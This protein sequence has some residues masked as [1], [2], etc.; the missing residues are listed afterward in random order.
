MPSPFKPPLVATP[1]RLGA[2]VALSVGLAACGGDPLELGASSSSAAVS[3]SAPASSS[4]A[5]SS[6]VASSARSSSLPASSSLLSRSSKASSSAKSSAS[7]AA[8]LVDLLKGDGA[9]A[10]GASNF[11]PYIVDAA[12]TVTFT[13]SADFAITKTSAQTYMVQITH[14]L[15]VA[16][17]TEY[18]VCFD[19]QAPSARTLDVA[20]DGGMDSD[21]SN[22]G[23]A[24][25]VNI[26]AGNWASYSQVITGVTT[27]TTARLAFNAGST[28]T[29]VNL[30]LDNIAVYVGNTCPASPQRFTVRP[31]TVQGS[32]I[33]Y[34]G[35]HT[36]Y[37]GVSLF[38]SDWGSKFYNANAVKAV[39]NEW[40]AKIIRAPLHVDNTGDDSFPWQ[41]YLTKD[42]ALLDASNK[43]RVFTVVDAAIA[44]DMYVIVDWHSHYAE[45]YKQQ[46]ID[47]FKEVA[48]KYGDKANLIYEIY[49]EPY[50]GT[51]WSSVIKPYAIDVIKAI[52]AID[53]DNL[54]IVGTQTYSQDVD[55]AANDPIQGFG[56]I[57][58]TLH[59][60]ADTHKA[61]MRSKATTALK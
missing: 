36:S 56:N 46:A 49:N 60:Y 47:F 21:Y 14:P 1:V 24:K 48:T 44:N 16:S 28:T 22:V 38:H 3:S 6:S 43:T 8:P 53:P 29:P 26:A 35:E 61:D 4:L 20:F 34:G 27:D 2:L 59:F 55:I 33:L 41:T 39:K 17:G 30:K 40:G 15:S 57:A 31:I 32:K 50:P 42:G 7:S 23:T 9:F 11:A 58:Y 25:T 54:I 52:R 12:N 51:D 45:R 19:A 13:D 37:A 10:A 5:V 18:V